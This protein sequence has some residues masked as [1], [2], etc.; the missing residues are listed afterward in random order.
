MLRT[1]NLLTRM[2]W[3]SFSAT[4]DAEL[5]AGCV[6]RCSVVLGLGSGTTARIRGIMADMSQFLQEVVGLVGHLVEDAS[7]SC[8]RVR[9]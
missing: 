7:L 6:A 9:P 1:R 3:S 8:R 4:T 5:T 2:G